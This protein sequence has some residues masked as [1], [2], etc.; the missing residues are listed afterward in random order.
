MDLETEQ[1]RKQT[2][3]QPLVISSVD[4]ITG[5]AY[6]SPRDVS[7]RALGMAGSAP[8]FVKGHSGNPSGRPKGASP[9]AAARRYLGENPDADGDGARAKRLGRDWAD[10]VLRLAEALAQGRLDDATVLGRALESVTKVIDSLDPEPKEKHVTTT[11]QRVVLSLTGKLPSDAAQLPI[12]PL[13]LHD[14]AQIGSKREDAA[15][16]DA[17]VVSGGGGSSETGSGPI[18]DAPLPLRSTASPSPPTP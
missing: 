4:P 16:R 18:L 2:Q 9:R 8:L 7:A 1:G 12:M 11:A 14:D 5:R 13:M 15:P 17:E 3:E 6:K 10:A